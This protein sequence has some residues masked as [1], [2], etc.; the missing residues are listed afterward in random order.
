[1]LN[2]SRFSSCGSRNWNSSISFFG[3]HKLFFQF[4]ICVLTDWC[5]VQRARCKGTRWKIK[6]YKILV[7]RLGKS[8]LGSFLYSFMSYHFIP[9]WSMGCKCRNV[10]WLQSLGWG[11]S[12]GGDIQKGEVRVLKELWPLYED[13]TLTFVLCKGAARSAT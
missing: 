1:M 3:E 8:H 5:R 4:S 2:A 6:V 9:I 7:E 13:Y 11:A 12:F 10:K